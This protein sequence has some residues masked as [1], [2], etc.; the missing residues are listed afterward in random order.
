MTSNEHNTSVLAVLRARMPAGAWDTHFHTTHAPGTD[1]DH[2]VAE[3]LA[4]Q[5]SIG[6]ARGVLIQARLHGATDAAAYLERSCM[7]GPS[8]IAERICQYAKA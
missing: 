8:H 2:P 4:L 3:A 6:V 1:H 5:A 7:A